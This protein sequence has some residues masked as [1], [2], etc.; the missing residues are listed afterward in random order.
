MLWLNF[1]KWDTSSGPLFIKERLYR[2]DSKNGMRWSPL[3]RLKLR[4]FKT[5]EEVS[6]FKNKFI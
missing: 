3:I 4:Y 1:S 5:S 6:E 2:Y